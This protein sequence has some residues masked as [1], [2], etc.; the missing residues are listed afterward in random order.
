[1]EMIITYMHVSM[2]SGCLSTCHFGPLS[3]HHR[4]PYQQDT[5]E[6]IRSYMRSPFP[7]QKDLPT[8]FTEQ[9]HFQPF[10]QKTF[11]L[12]HPRVKE[13][14]FSQIPKTV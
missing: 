5:F 7:S 1:M 11:D 3:T 8:N 4:I 12:Y 10:N 14:Y 13:G 2:E 6:P 9:E